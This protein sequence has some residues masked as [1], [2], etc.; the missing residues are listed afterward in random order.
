MF[1]DP[2]CTVIE[3]DEVNTSSEWVAL[4]EDQK[5]SALKWGRIYLDSKYECVDA[6]PEETLKL[7]NALLGGY[8][9]KSNIFD[10]SNPGDALITEKSIKAGSVSIG[11]KFT[12]GNS[13]YS[14]TFDLYPDV[15]AVLSQYCNRKTSGFSIKSV[16]RS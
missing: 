9:S 3:A 15:S 13:N 6:V 8:H 10:L 11:K 1:Q 16:I 14:K 7:A 5:L 12:T 4:S 2:Y